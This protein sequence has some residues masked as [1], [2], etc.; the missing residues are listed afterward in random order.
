MCACVCVCVLFLTYSS[1]FCSP[2]FLL[3]NYSWTNC[4]FLYVWC[5]SSLAAFKIFSL[6]L[7]FT[8]WI[9]VCLDPFPLFWFF[10][11]ITELTGFLNQSFYIN[12]GSFQLLFFPICNFASF[13]LLSGRVTYMLGYII[14]FHTFMCPRSFSFQLLFLYDFVLSNYYLYVFQ[15]CDSFFFHLQNAALNI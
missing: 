6:I 9:I 3:R 10:I 1:I 8:S 14:L 7:V 4:C 12:F 11:D 5:H 13:S 15:F 2:L